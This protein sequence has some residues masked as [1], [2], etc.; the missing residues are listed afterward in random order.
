MQLGGKRGLRILHLDHGR[1]WGVQVARR[2]RMRI[3]DSVPCA[4]FVPPMARAMRTGAGPT[5]ARQATTSTWGNKQN[6]STTLAPHVAGGMAVRLASA[7]AIIIA[8]T[9]TMRVPIAASE[10]AKITLVVT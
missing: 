6:A 8:C 9:L 3:P 4:A 1:H 10:R 2:S 7:Q 5:R